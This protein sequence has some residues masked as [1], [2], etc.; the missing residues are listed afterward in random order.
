MLPLFVGLVLDTSALSYI[1]ERRIDISQYNEHEI[2]VPAAVAE[3]N[4][5]KLLRTLYTLRRAV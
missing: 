2:F 3:E 5:I 1:A 4:T